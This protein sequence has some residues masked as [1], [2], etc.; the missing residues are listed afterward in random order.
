MKKSTW[1]IYDFL[2]VDPRCSVVLQERLV[3]RH[4]FQCYFMA[5]PHFL[6]LI[7]TNGLNNL[8]NKA[9][10]AGYCGSEWVNSEEGV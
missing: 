10:C 6:A 7:R 9:V 4:M 8:S 2:K 5:L 3:C 1:N